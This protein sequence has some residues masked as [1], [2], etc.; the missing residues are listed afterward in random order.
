MLTQPARAI[1]RCC[2]HLIPFFEN[3][4]PQRDASL[5]WIRA[6]AAFFVVLIH[7]CSKQFYTFTASWNIC[8]LYESSARMSVAL[9]AIIT[10]YLV[11]NNKN[12]YPYIFLRR[13]LTKILVPFFIVMFIYYMLSD[14]T[15]YI[16]LVKLLRNEVD[17]HL[18]Y[19]YVISGIYF[20][21]PF[22]NSLFLTTENK[23]IKNYFIMLWFS[24][25]I[26]FQF[27]IALSGKNNDPFGI[28]NFFCFTGYVVFGGAL[29]KESLQ[30]KLSKNSLVYLCGYFASSLLICALTKIYSKYLGKPSELF[31]EHFSIFVFVQS[32]MFFL[33][34]KSSQPKTNP[35]IVVLSKLSYN[36]YLI[37][38]LILNF[39][40]KNMAIENYQLIAIPAITL[41]VYILSAIV[42]IPLYQAG[43]LITRFLPWTR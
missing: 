41:L 14:D 24:G 27:Y 28:F 21:I 26:I 13:R 32:M 11:L 6:S 4:E 43:I 37:H 2:K 17:F 15:A 1:K 34:I 16:F 19:V 29:R 9:F 7:V 25:S 23:Y 42:S 5:D 30:Q 33:F 20:I 36:I 31:F 3:V 10:G 35:Y 22:L 18:W 39:I 12:E 40:Y 38:V 8:I